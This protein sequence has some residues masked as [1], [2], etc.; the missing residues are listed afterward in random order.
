[1]SPLA[2]YG[3]KAHHRCLLLRKPYIGC[4]FGAYHFAVFPCRNFCFLAVLYR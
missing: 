3:G 4:N 1:V 2:R